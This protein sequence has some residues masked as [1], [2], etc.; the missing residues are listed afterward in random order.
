[1]GLDQAASV[2]VGNDYIRGVS[3]GQRRRVSL[4]EALCTRAG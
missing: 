1:M 4:A 3:G 2:R